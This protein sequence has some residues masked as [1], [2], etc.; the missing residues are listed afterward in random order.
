MN[1]LYCIAC[2]VVLLYIQYKNVFNLPI[3]LEY[4]DRIF[5][6]SLMVAGNC[7]VKG[8]NCSYIP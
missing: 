1:V 4:T 5:S 6:T 7:F 2:D 3:L 8:H